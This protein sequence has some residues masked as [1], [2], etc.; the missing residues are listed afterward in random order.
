MVLASALSDGRV[1]PGTTYGCIGHLFPGQPDRWRCDAK[2]GHGTV[3]PLMAIQKSCNVFFYHV[4]ENM[5]V[6][7]LRKWFDLFGL[8]RETGIGLLESPGTITPLRKGMGKGPARQMAIGQGEV[9]MTPLQAANMT[10]T[11]ASGVWRPVTIWPED[12]RPQPKPYRL[13]IPDAHWRLVREGMYKVVNEQGGTAYG[14]LRAKLAGADEFVFLGKTGS[15]EPPA[16]EYL[17]RCRFPDGREEIIKAHSFRELLQRYPEGQ[18]PEYLGQE[19]A[20]EYPTHG[21][22]I[23]YLTTR[24]KYLEPAIDGELDVAIAVIVE[25]AGHGGA[26]AAPV[27]RDM[28]QAMITLHR[29]GQIQTA[30]ASQPVTGPAGAV[31][32]ANG[33]GGEP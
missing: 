2:W 19:P 32:D 17:Y 10:A 22:F 6:A 13:P 29:G 7:P 15:A 1:G 3:D 25:Y 18:K 24:G 28:I 31:A 11:I 4:G 21:W 26:V 9:G 27:A 33:T 14:P 20:A 30:P 16:I 8:G 12:P 5:Q 23:G